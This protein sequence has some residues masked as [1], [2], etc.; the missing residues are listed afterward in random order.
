MELAAFRRENESASDSK[1]LGDGGF[2]AADRGRACLVGRTPPRGA[3]A[4]ARKPCQALKIGQSL[5]APPVTPS[6]AFARGRI[7]RAAL[8]NCLNSARAPASFRRRLTAADSFLRT[9]LRF[10]AAAQAACGGVEFTHDQV[11]RRMCEG[12]P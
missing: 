6:L 2:P 5:R 12:T 3:G 1:Q 4:E 7:G 9:D 11:L 10:D 8:R